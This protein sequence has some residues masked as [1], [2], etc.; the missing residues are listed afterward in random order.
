MLLNKQ[1]TLY[2]SA[3]ITFVHKELISH[4]YMEQN[5]HLKKMNRS[6]K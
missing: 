6:E 3:F 2:S 1:Y 4:N 5:T